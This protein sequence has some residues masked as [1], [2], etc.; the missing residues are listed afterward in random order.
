MAVDTRTDDLDL[1]LDRFVGVA[2]QAY[3]TVPC[4]LDNSFSDVSE[5]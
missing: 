5:L 1:D 3:S 4:F 2:M